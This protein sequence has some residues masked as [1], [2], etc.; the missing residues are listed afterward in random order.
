MSKCE[1]SGLNILKYIR[2]KNTTE[3][4]HLAPQRYLPE[5]LVKILKQP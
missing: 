3:L 1:E 5:G 2:K 4:L